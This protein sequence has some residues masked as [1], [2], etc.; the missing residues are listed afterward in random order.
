MELLD[1]VTESEVDSPAAN[2]APHP[3][4]QPPET[5]LRPVRQSAGSTWDRRGPPGSFGKP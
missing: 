5:G 1:L 2:A 3:D 4:S